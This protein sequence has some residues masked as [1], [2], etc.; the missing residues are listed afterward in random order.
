VSARCPP[1]SDP[2]PRP[3]GAISPARPPGQRRAQAAD[4]P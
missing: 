2:R 3:T 1:S 4:T